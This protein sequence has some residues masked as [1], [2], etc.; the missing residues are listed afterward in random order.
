MGYVR[1][2]E[3]R[4]G[5]AR[6]GRVCFLLHP[7]IVTFL[8]FVNP[9]VPSPSLCH[10]LSTL[11]SF[12]LKYFVSISIPS[13]AFVIFSLSQSTNLFPT[14]YWTIWLI[15]S[16]LL[17]RSSVTP[18]CF[19]EPTS[20]PFSYKILS[21][22]IPLTV[23]TVSTSFSFPLNYQTLLLFIFQNHIAFT[24]PRSMDCV[25]LLSLSSRAQPTD[26]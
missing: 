1:W 11:T 6:V 25:R 26:R 24:S 9:S 12:L 5:D 3:V 23:Y 18:C 4:W 22:L 2:R 14:V 8:L 13:S 17:P 20:I 21:D 10:T 19:S 15:S 16:V 7:C